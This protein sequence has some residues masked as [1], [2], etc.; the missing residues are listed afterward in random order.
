MSAFGLFDGMLLCC[1]SSVLFWCLMTEITWHKILGNNVNG[2]FIPCVNKGVSIS[3][4][5]PNITFLN[6]TVEIFPD[7]MLRLS[8]QSEQIGI[9]PN[10]LLWIMSK[11]SVSLLAD[12]SMQPAPSIALSDVTACGFVGE[13]EGRGQVRE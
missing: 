5:Y 8:K 6:L 10:V 7:Y 13:G 9:H 11:K 4:L 3:K 1:V 12:G 2:G